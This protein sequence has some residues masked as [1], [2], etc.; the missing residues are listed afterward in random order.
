MD[1]NDFHL[2][3][4]LYRWSMAIALSMMVLAFVLAFAYPPQNSQPCLDVSAS[5]QISQVEVRLP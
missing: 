2:S 5:S 1:F 3:T 4:N